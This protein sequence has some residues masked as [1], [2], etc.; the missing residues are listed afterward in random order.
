MSLNTSNTSNTLE[1]CI[2][3]KFHPPLVRSD[4]IKRPHMEEELCSMVT[5]L[6]LTL[7]SAPAGYGKTTLLSAIPSLLPG[8]P[9]AWISLEAEDNDPVRFIGLL[10]TALQKLHSDCGTTVWSLISGGGVSGSGMKHAIGILKTT[11]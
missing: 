7:L 1:W 4:I 3:T 5:T 11:P 8:Y 9:L 2:A 10:I 6:P